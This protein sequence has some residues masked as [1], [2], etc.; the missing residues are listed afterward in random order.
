MLTFYCSLF[1]YQLHQF[2]RE[3][4]EKPMSGSQTISRRP[5]QLAHGSQAITAPAKELLATIRQ[6]REKTLHMMTEAGESS[7]MMTPRTKLPTANWN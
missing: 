3:D 1:V 7:R 4:Y 2:A 6:R 5:S